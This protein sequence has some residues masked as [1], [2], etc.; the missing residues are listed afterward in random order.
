MILI[1][2]ASALLSTTTISTRAS[3]PTASYVTE[4][5][6]EKRRHLLDSHSLGMGTRAVMEELYEIAENCRLENWDAQG[7]SAIDQETF[8]QAYR[9]LEALPLG[10]IPPS[11][12]V[13]P[14]GQI[15]L[16][17]YKSTRKTL[18][19]SVSPEGDLHY[20]AIVGL[21]KSYGTEAFFGEIPKPIFELLN[22]VLGA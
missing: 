5:V 22:R 12:G 17:W 4:Q 10:F 7:A 14:D 18:S 16:E 2:T 8:R 3:S 15:T 11:I 13:E 19:I 9:F 1:M 21:N 20:S 6:E